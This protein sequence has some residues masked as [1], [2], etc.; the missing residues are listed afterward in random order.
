MDCPK[1]LEVIEVHSYEEANKFLKDNWTLL[2]VGF[3]Q[4]SEPNKSYHSYSLGY[5]ENAIVN[6]ELDEKYKNYDLGF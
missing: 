3:H 5:T 6:K 2:S 4:S 1:F